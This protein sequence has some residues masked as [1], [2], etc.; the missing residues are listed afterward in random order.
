M[1][2]KLDK[3]AFAEMEYATAD[4]TAVDLLG[5]KAEV[6]REDVHNML[7]VAGMTP[8][9]GNIADAVDAVLY[10]VEGEFGSAALSAAAMTP[11]IGQ[12]VSA[13][14]A[15]KVAKE[16]G[17]QMVTVYRGVDKWHPGSM[18]KKGR[19]VGGG[20]YIGKENW[21]SGA[22]PKETLWTTQDKHSALAYGRRGRKPFAKE[23]VLLEF[24]IP[25]SYLDKFASTPRTK[26]LGTET[27]GNILETHGQFPFVFREGLPKEFL[28]KVYK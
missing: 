17:E 15:L 23:P 7:M 2:D 4:K 22:L 13:K 28:K 6:T 20:E 16:S 18:V 3:R 1:A 11:F 9:L 10:A 5:D 26:Q 24:E 27:V 25:R 21:S 19:F 8:A 12:A 14:K